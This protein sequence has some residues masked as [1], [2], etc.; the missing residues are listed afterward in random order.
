MSSKTHTQMLFRHYVVFVLR[1]YVPQLA[2]PHLGYSDH[3]FISLSSAYR[4]LIT[5]SKPILKQA[6]SSSQEPALLFRTVLTTYTGRSQGYLGSYT[7]E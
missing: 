5:H 6:I 3:I 4:S 7:V 1:I 2:P